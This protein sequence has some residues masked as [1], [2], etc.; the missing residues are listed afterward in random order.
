MDGYR[1]IASRFARRR[2]LT[3]AV[4][5][6]GSVAF[7]FLAGDYTAAEMRWCIVV[8]LIGALIFPL[9][10]TVAL[11]RALAPVRA[12]VT[13]GEGDA[14][15]IARDLR[16]LPRR[17]AF[18]WLVSFQLIA[19]SAIVGGNLLAGLPP[20]RNMVDTVAGGFLCWAMYAT[21]L[22][23]AFEHA[24]ASFAALAARATGGSLP[25]PRLTTGGIAG[26]ITLVIVVTVVFVTAVTGIITMHGANAT[27][28]VITGFV[29]VIYG[30]LAALFLAESIAAPM[31]QL[32]RAL[33]RVAEG[34]LD[35]LAE[36]RAT[37]RV[38][39][40]V[41]MVLHA[42]AGA[43]SSLRASADATARLAGGDLATTI[44]P[45]GAG[46]FLNRALAA[47]LGSVREVLGDARGAARVL[48]DG[49]ARIDANA[50]RLRGAATTI[51]ADLQAASASVE[52]LENATVD[53]GAAS[54][55]LTTAVSDVGTSADLLDDAVRETAAALEELAATVEQHAEIALAI[56]GIAHNATT[57]AAGASQA[58]AAAAGAGDTAVGALGTTRGGIEALHTASE[59][60][61]DITRTIDEIADQTNLLALNAAIEAARAGEHGRGFAVV[62]DEIRKLADRSGAATREIAAVI[63]DVQARTGAAVTATREGDAAARTAREST[64]KA[65]E[66]LDAIVGDVNEVARRLDD[67][68]RSHEEQRVTTGQL[69]RATGAV[70][71]QAARNRE[72]ASGLGTL[73]DQ[74]ATIAAQ[75]AQAA[76][77]A[78]ERVATAVRAGAD[79]ANEAT[80]LSELT[81]GLRDAS[82]RL[83]DAIAR[84]REDAPAESQPSHGE[85]LAL[86]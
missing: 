45:R 32:A 72:V 7:I 40:E 26:R 14:E 49:S 55:D 31:A 86:R 85:P 83:D 17:F 46:D 63:R 25:A 36:L 50:G 5:F 56:R 60:I 20:T 16:K 8:G 58:L 39:H 64:A 3:I 28:F 2:I 51:A 35:A 37:P 62:A 80:G 82:G 27:A 69:V 10:Q 65:A 42:L 57:V 61:G 18:W 1:Q 12:A 33:D 75:G 73:A 78:R 70:R 4:S 24:L 53:A 9:T 41:G 81:T 34:D 15:R 23:L 79:V 21:L 71:D 38:E 76:D 74:L 52:R 54:I 43:E 11:R 59:R 30:A 19:L 44:A 68:G 6:I 66:A 48:A 47:L 84:F 77:E 13:T 22:S 29:I 67:V